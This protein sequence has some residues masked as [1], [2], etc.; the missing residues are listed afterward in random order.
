MRYSEIVEK[1]DAEKEAVRSRKKQAQLMMKNAKR[2][3]ELA[4]AADLTLKQKQTQ[5]TLAKINSQP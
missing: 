3:T 1:C 4:K 5:Q 2:A